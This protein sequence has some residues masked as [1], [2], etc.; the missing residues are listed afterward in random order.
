M[1]PNY[2]SVKVLKSQNGRRERGEVRDG[3]P[4]SVFLR[5]AGTGT[6]RRLTGSAASRNPSSANT[7]KIGSEP[8]SPNTCPPAPRGARTARPSDGPPCTTARKWPI[9]ESALSVLDPGNQSIAP[10]V[11]GRLL[12]FGAEEHS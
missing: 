7:P 4:S 6:R 9:L 10:S 5:S 8:G 11:R 2:R 12:A 1:G 3:L